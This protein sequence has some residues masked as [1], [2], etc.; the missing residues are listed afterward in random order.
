MSFFKVYKFYVNLVA[1][2]GFKK[3]RRKQIRQKLMEKTA[4]QFIPYIARSDQNFL[5]QRVH[6]DEAYHV[7]QN[8]TFPLRF[9]KITKAII[10][11][12]PEHDVISGGIFSMFSIANQLRKWKLKY[13][14]EVILMT[15]PN[16]KDST[17]FRNTTFINSENIYRFSQIL[18]M[19]NLKELYLH[20]PEYATVDFFKHLGNEELRKLLGLQRLDINILNQNIR[21]MPEPDK[22]A[23]L[24]KISN[25]VTQS[26]AHHAYFSQKIAD[27][28]DLPT[29][30]LPAYTD[31]TPYPKSE[32][33]QKEKLII[34]SFDEAPH[35]VECL[36]ILK[37]D[38]PEFTFLKIENMTF[39]VFMEYATRCMFSI[40]FGEGFDGYIAQPIY[41]GGIGLTVYND[42]FFPSESFKQYP[43]F[44]DSERD[45]L[46][47]IVNVI[48]RLSTNPTEYKE[49]NQKLVAEYDKLYSFDEYVQ[50]VEKL[51]RKEF[52]IF[53]TQAK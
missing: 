19:Q 13:G 1:M 29:L 14:Y 34:Y 44:F 27:D 42:D 21:L 3:Q 5:E 28:Y 51:A 17:Y 11:L 8:I 35:K 10:I 40:S 38:L 25:S 32:F 12:V 39:D 23:Y 33:E 30:F 2:L 50:Q 41:Q 45:M 47:N 9:E 18:R 16:A 6:E 52:E 49:L 26:V 22:Y 53:P 37:R 20:I 36:K 48:K 46:N 31:L 15:R 7:V 24:R 4:K 43:N